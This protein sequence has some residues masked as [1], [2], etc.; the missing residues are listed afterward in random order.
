[1]SSSTPEPMKINASDD[2]NSAKKARQ[3]KAKLLNLWKIGIDKRK[4]ELGAFQDERK[5]LKQMQSDQEI[6]EEIR[7]LREEDKVEFS[8]PGS[9]DQTDVSE[10]SS[11]EKQKKPEGKETETQ[12]VE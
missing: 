10:S 3:K 6:M 4:R 2:P 12:E 1:M 5:I 9:Q 11:P 8:S 7:A